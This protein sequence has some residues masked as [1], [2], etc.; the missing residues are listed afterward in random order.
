MTLIQLRIYQSEHTIVWGKYIKSRPIAR[1]GIFPRGGAINQN[2]TN[3]KRAATE[4]VIIFII[5]RQ[6]TRKRFPA[7]F[8]F[9]FL[10]R[11]TGLWYIMPWIQDAARHLPCSYESEIA[12][13]I[14][15][16]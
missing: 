9:L 8:T 4:S 7:P 14:S 13:F 2:K 16:R 15:L 6:E 3:K 11:G 12:I 5:A 1:K 10:P